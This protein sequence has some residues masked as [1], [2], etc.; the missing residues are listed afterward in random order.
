M[1]GDIICADHFSEHH[2]VDMGVDGEKCALLMMGGCTKITDVA[3]V[4][5]KS[6]NEAVVALK[7]FVGNHGVRSM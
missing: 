2:G 5:T 4:K 6:A 7:T 3:P 1:L